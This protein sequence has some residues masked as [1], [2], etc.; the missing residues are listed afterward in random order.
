MTLRVIAEQAILWFQAYVRCGKGEAEAERMA[1][2]QVEERYG[3]DWTVVA[4]EL[5][6]RPIGVLKEEIE[7]R[8]PGV[9]VVQRSQP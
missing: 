9:M 5:V 8:F 6:E 4:V 2:Q 1:V 7:R 3:A